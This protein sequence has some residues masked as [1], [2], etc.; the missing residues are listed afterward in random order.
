MNPFKLQ[1]KDLQLC[2]Y[3]FWFVISLK[4]NSFLWHVVNIYIKQDVSVET[5]FIMMVVIAF[6]K[7]QKPMKIKSKHQQQADWHS[8]TLLNLVMT[9]LLQTSGRSTATRV[10]VA[11]F[12]VV[13]FCCM[14]TSAQLSVC[15]CIR[16][17]WRPKTNTNSQADND[18]RGWGLGTAP[19][20]STRHAILLFC[21]KI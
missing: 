9:S 13:V 8:G 2:H 5:N 1:L 14:H 11:F 10:E 12:V 4:F 18:N 17:G 3:G 19:S 20:V 6:I 21:L 7:Q 16:S 15:V